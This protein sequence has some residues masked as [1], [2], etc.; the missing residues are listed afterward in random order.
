MNDTNTNPLYAAAALP[1]SSIRAQINS[2]VFSLAGAGD[3][4]EKAS[5][6]ALRSMNMA[7][8]SGEESIKRAKKVLSATS[9]ELPDA[10]GDAVVEFLVGEG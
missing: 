3:E 4:F 8:Q 9:G 10:L 5:S 6:N 7:I 1:K 2:A